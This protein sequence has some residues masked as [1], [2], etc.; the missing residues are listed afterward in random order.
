MIRPIQNVKGIQKPTGEFVFSWERPSQDEGFQYLWIYCLEDA[1][2]TPRL[3]EYTYEV[4][5]GVQERFD[6]IAGKQ[7]RILR[8][9]ILL[10]NTKVSPAREDVASAVSS[11]EN[12]C[13]VPSGNATVKYCWIKDGSGYKLIISTDSALPSD[14]LF[15]SYFFCGKEF[16]FFIPTSMLMNSG[17]KES[18][19]VFFP[20][21][22]GIPPVQSVYSNIQM[23]PL[24]TESKGQDKK[25]FWLFGKRKEN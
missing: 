6:S 15:Y 25:K 21:D 18:E 5:T 2:F 12:Y 20:I 24:Q 17:E 10:S 7:F 19:T 13:I 11:C 23:I 1:S 14:T 3:Y 22:G 8:F 16:R 4:Y 9:V